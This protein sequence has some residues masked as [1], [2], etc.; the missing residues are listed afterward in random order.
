MRNS[1]PTYRLIQFIWISHP[2]TNNGNTVKKTYYSKT[3]IIRHPIIR[4]FL[5]TVM[6]GGQYIWEGT[7]EKHKRSLSHG[8]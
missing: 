6:V 7:K 8:V 4:Q 5:L 1:N 2:G 3:S